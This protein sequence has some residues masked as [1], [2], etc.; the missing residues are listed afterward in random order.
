MYMRRSFLPTNFGV[1][2]PLEPALETAAGPHRAPRVGL[3][4]ASFLTFPCPPSPPRATC[5]SRAAGRPRRRRIA[6]ARHPHRYRTCGRCYCYSEP[7]PASARR[8]LTAQQSSGNRVVAG[9]AMHHGLMSPNRPSQTWRSSQF[10]RMHTSPKLS[11]PWRCADRGA[12]RRNNTVV[13][14]VRQTAGDSRG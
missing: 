10:V 4:W 14:V 5:Q 13:T 12:A 1:S 3:G 8:L 7:R 11:E 6:T 2:P 9:S